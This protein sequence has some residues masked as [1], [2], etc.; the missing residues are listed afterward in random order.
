MEKKNEHIV[1]VGAGAA[2]LATAYR[3]LEEGFSVTVFEASDRTGGRVLHTEDFADFP[4]ELGASYIHGD[5]S[6]LFQW[7]E[8]FDLPFIRKKSGFYYIIDGKVLS[9]AEAEEDEDILDY[10]RFYDEHHTYAGE[11]KIFSDLLKEVE[12]PERMSD[13]YESFAEMLGTQS[14]NLGIK[15]IAHAGTHWHSGD[16]NYRLQV[17]YRHL[18]DGMEE[19]VK[20]FIQFGKEVRVLDASHGNGVRV[21]TSDCTYEEADRVVLTVPLTMLK[22]RRIQFLPLLNEEKITAIDGIGMDGKGL[23]V[24]LKFKK[25]FWPVNMSELVGG[26]IAAEYWADGHGKEGQ[27]AVLVAFAMGKKADLLT[28]LPESKA[29]ALLLHELDSLFAGFPSELFSEALFTNWAKM[30]FIEGSY[31]YAS[32]DS[33]SL[34]RTLAQKHAERIYFAGEATCRGHFGTVHGAIESGL[35]ATEEILEDISTSNEQVNNETESHS[36]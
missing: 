27:D 29:I 1:V 25:P 12:A 13:L 9:E 4:I 15:S 5:N 2:G 20:P 35:R 7:A 36:L 24:L 28:A 6:V 26:N 8:D 10:F 33:Y 17:P 3:L 19:V 34:R 14:E 18:L 22:Q 31:S 32:P 23:K 30:P 21:V 16:E 11:E